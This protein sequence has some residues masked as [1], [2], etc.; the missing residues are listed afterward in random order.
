MS[1]LEEEEGG[2]SDVDPGDSISNIGI[3]MTSP[4]QNIDPTA[5]VEANNQEHHIASVP[6]VNNIFFR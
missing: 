6:N 1:A 2:A 4:L 5:H 3:N